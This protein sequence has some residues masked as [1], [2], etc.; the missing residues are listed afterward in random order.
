MTL[1]IPLEAQA[2]LPNHRYDLMLPLLSGRVAIE[3]VEIVPS[4]ATERAGYFDN[5][6]F[7]DGDFGVVLRVPA[8]QEGELDRVIELTLAGAPSGGATQSR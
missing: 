6:K 7:Q 3:G 5:P 2:A 4:G 8:E 1:Q